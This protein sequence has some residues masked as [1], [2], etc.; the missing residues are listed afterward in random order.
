MIL[1][2]SNSSCILVMA[3]ASLGFWYFARYNGNAGKSMEASEAVGQQLA[4]I[5]VANSSST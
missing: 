4:G 3:S 1:V 5:L 2:S